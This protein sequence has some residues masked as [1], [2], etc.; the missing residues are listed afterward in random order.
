MASICK[1]LALCA[2]LLAWHAEGSAAA[3]GC[4][5]S[6]NLCDDRFTPCCTG[7]TCGDIM[8]LGVGGMESV[9][10]CMQASG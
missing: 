4:A 6:G 9:G 7:L 10:T 3:E 8:R 2:A 5:T 1:L